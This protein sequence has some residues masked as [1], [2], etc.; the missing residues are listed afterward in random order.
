MFVLSSCSFLKQSM[1]YIVSSDYYRHC[2]IC[3]WEW[4]QDW[5][6][7][8]GVQDGSKK[9]GILKVAHLTNLYFQFYCNVCQIVEH[10][11][12]VKKNQFLKFILGKLLFWAVCQGVFNFSYVAKIIYFKFVCAPNLTTRQWRPNTLF[13]KWFWPFLNAALPVIKD[14]KVTPNTNGKLSRRY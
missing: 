13:M 5:Y 7:Q 3:L 1:K 2:I 12:V 9:M 11:L 4:S 8:N 14:I 6:I 10:A